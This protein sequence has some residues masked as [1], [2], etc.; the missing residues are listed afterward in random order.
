MA[1][2]CIPRGQVVGIVLDAC[3]E[4]AV[5]GPQGSP[6]G[7][8]IWTVLEIA[9]VCGTWTLE[10][11][12]GIVK[13]WEISLV[14]WILFPD[15]DDSRF[16]PQGIVSLSWLR[17]MDEASAGGP[18][19]AHPGPQAAMGAAAGHQREEIAGLVVEGGLGT[20]TPA[21]GALVS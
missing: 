4:V 16:A 8:E 1:P 13:L 5:V 14:I 11:V 18:G 3:S 20:P 10:N 2:G 17:G 21:Y 7:A 6:A 12:V 19:P 15:R 9:V